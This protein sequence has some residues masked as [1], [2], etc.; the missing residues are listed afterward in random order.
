MLQYL[1]FSDGIENCKE[2]DAIRTL[3]VENLIAEIPPL[4]W[5]LEGNKKGNSKKN[6]LNYSSVP[7]TGIEPAHP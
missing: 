3:R 4:K 5:D 1:V 7:G 6:C 2:N